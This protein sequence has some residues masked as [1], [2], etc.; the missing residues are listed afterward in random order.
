[1]TTS[2][3]SRKPEEPRQH[4]AAIPAAATPTPTAKATASHEAKSQVKGHTKSPQTTIDPQLLHWSQFRPLDLSIAWNRFCQSCSKATTFT[5]HSD[6]DHGLLA[7][8]GEC[9][10]AVLAPWTRTTPKL[11][12]VYNAKCLHCGVMMPI[13]EAQHH[14]CEPGAIAARKMSPAPR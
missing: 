7:K 6:C 8:C 11:E 2:S 14:M 10:T 3:H 1:M 12:R 13:A 5:A 9:G 4:R